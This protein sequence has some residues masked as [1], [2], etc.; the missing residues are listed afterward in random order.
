MTNK[1]VKPENI[2]GISIYHD[3]KKGTIFYDFLGRKGYA[4]T[5]SDVQS[6]ARYSLA[7]PLSLLCAFGLAYVFSLGYAKGVIVF[8]VLYVIFKLIFRYF[9]LRDLVEMD[10]WKPFKRDNLIVYFAKNFSVT[11]LIILMLMLIA[12]AALMP[13]NAIINSYGQANL[14]VSCVIAAMAAIAA[15]LTLVALIVKKRNNY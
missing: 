5:S 1:K 12:L 6:Y 14:Y 3:P 2:D 7:F 15:V 10:N 11:R 9:F 13:V 8:A 4:I